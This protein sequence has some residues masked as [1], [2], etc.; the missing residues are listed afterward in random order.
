MA[1]VLG[2]SLQA[3]RLRRRF[4]TGSPWGSSAR[5]FSSAQDAAVRKVLEQAGITKLLVANRGE[6]AV[7]ICLG[8]L[9]L[10]LGASALSLCALPCGASP[11]PAL[12]LPCYFW[13]PHAQWPRLVVCWRA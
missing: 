5:A 1:Q 7:S 13:E 2:L 8:Q 4:T 3:L 11:W 10:G 12:H 9:G 6:I